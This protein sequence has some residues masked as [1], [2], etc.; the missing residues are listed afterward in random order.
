M[1]LVRVLQI[2]AIPFL[3]YFLSFAVLVYNKSFYEVRIEHANGMNLTHVLFD[4][5][6]FKSSKINFTGLTEEEVSHLADVRFVLNSYFVFSTLVFLLFI[7]SLI[8]F[9]IDR[10]VVF[11]GSLVTIICSLVFAVFPFNFIF[12]LFHNLFF[13]SRSWIFPENYL[14]VSV[15]TQD[16]FSQFFTRIVVQALIMSVLLI[17]IACFKKKS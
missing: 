3:V 13:K 14:L 4:Y 1:N 8:F 16:F 12:T 6:Q 2:I 9:G 17:L 15:Y 5:F 7:M 10:N 11:S